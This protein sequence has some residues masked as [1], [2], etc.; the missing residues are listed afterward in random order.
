MNDPVFE[1]LDGQFSSFIDD[2]TIGLHGFIVIDSNINGRSVGGLRVEKNTTIE[3]TKELARS[4]TLK[5]GFLGLNRGGAK[6]SIIADGENLYSH[7]KM[8]LL[9]RFAEIAKPLLCESR[10]AIGS[11]MNTPA[12]EI[13]RMLEFIGEDV[14]KSKKLGNSGYYTA[15]TVFITA[16]EYAIFKKI[17]LTSSTIVI[18]GFGSVGSNAAKLFAKKGCKVIAI[19][20][21]SGAI[22]NQ[23]G[24]NITELLKLKERDGS[25]LVLHKGNWEQLSHSELLELPCDFLVPAARGKSINAKN[26]SRI[27]ARV[28]CPGANI[29]VTLQGEK[30]LKDRGLFSV[31]FFVANC[32][33]VLGDCMEFEGILLQKIKEVFFQQLSKRIR[34]ALE[35]SIMS[36]DFPR[37][38]MENRVLENFLRI[39]KKTET[40]SV[41]NISFWSVAKVLK[42]TGF[43]PRFVVQTYWEKYYENLLR[44][45]DYGYEK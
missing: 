20:T 2:S 29:P 18:E 27:Q 19:S 12:N 34:S 32:G 9:K 15:L 38:A 35:F 11:D 43:I 44:K 40:K 10:Y 14:D 1:S 37:K 5:C 33:G 30:I 22:Y 3:E 4:M 13:D 26:A 45:V 42:T 24:L 36:D 17:D 16:L 28:I 25:K 7:I 23:N 39:K 31:P 21:S 6:A 8:K 41:P